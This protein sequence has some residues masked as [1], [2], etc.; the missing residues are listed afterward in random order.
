M[1]KDSL[2]TP[3]PVFDGESYEFWRVQM[4]T[5]FI[6]QDLW[7]IVENGIPEPADAETL[8]TWTQAK[9]KEYRKNIRRDAKALLFIQQGVNRS[10]FPRIIGAKNCKKAWD[11]LKM[12][13][14][15]SEKVISI[16]FQ[17]LWR[18]FDTLAMKDNEEIRTFISR[19][20]EIINQIKSYGD[21]IEDK[22]IVEKVLWSLPQKFEHVVAAIE[23]SKDLSKLTM[24]EL[25]GSLEAHEKRMC[26]FVGPSI[27]QAFESKLKIAEK[28]KY[29]GHKDYFIKFDESFSSEVKMGDGKMQ[30]VE[31]KGTVAIRTKGESLLWHLRYGHLNYHGLRLLKQKNMVIGLPDIELLDQTCERCIYDKMHR[32]PFPKTAWRAR[33]PLELIH[34]DIC[35]PTRTSSFQN[36]KYFLLFVDDFSKMMWVYF[37]EQKSEAFAVF[38]RFKKMVERESNLQLKT[39]RTDRGGEFLSKE[40][41]N[42]CSQEGIQRQLTARYTP[43]QNGV[44]ERKNRTIV[45]MARSML[46]AKGLPYTFWAEA[47]NAAVYILNKSPTKANPN[48]TPYEDWHKRKPEI[49]H[50]R[51]FGCLAYSLIPSQ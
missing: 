45:E 5:L 6:S 30:P 1:S 24:M 43:Q 3:I 4:K 37:L 50:F 36:K 13:F 7:E 25:M 40:F 17:S 22:K 38:V 34:A 20:V 42:Y 23:E 19:V 46:K 51:V 41:S 49:R 31:G 21:T 12:E 35:G 11:I 14:Q 47:V 18:D 8:S 10:I 29:E 32:L 16:K 26:K 9:Q 28:K 15:G 33:Q 27:E 44:A 48:K 2:T 39:L